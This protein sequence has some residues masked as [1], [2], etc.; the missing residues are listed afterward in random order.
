L[1]RVVDA[2]DPV[3]CANWFNSGGQSMDVK[4]CY[5]D[6]GLFVLRSVVKEKGVPTGRI[7]H[8]A[9]NKDV[10]EIGGLNIREFNLLGGDIYDLPN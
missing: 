5:G 10:S 4:L 1:Y 6:K 8:G 2:T 9:N 3:D 7:P